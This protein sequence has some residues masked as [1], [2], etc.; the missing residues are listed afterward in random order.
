MSRHLSRLEHLRQ[1]PN[2][3]RNKRDAPSSY[4][5]TAAESAAFPALTTMTVVFFH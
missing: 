5:E 2:L 1:Y 3:A 4:A